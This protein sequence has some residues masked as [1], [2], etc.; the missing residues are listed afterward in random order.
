MSR[1][2]ASATSGRA[3]RLAAATGLTVA[4]ALAP[5]ALAAV[6]QAGRPVAIIGAAGGQSERLAAIAQAGG[7]IVGSV[8]DRMV[9]AVS[10]DPDFVSRLRD[11]GQWV[12]LDARAVPGCGFNGNRI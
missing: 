4:A 3:A 7:S 2:P 11:L 12:V 8:G 6:P 9:V 1:A 10:E 5:A